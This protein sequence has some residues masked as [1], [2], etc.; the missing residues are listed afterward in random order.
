MELQIF[1]IEKILRHPFLEHQPRIPIIHVLAPHYSIEIGLFACSV[2]CM[3]VLNCNREKKCNLS[4][5]KRAEIESNKK[6]LLDVVNKRAPINFVPSQLACNIFSKTFLSFLFSEIFFN[7]QIQFSFL[8]LLL[9]DCLDTFYILF[10]FLF[11]APKHLSCVK[12]TTEKITF[13]LTLT[14]GTRT[15]CHTQNRE[16]K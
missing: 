2:I 8:I 11:L 4:F 9:F 13:V 12:K 15:M 3:H 1:E 5:Q 10:V 6:K 7:F 16:Q 14:G